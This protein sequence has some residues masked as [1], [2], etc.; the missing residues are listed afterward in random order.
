MVPRRL[1]DSERQELVGRYK[2]GESTAALAEEFGCSPNTV[3]RTVKSLLPPEA[4]AALKASRQK[5]GAVSASASVHVDMVPPRSEVLTTAIAAN[6]DDSVV[7]IDAASA[8]KTAPIISSEELSSEDPSGLALNDA[9]DFGKEPEEQN[10]EYEDPTFF[11]VPTELVP[12]IGINELNNRTKTET[13][14]LSPGVLPNSVY[15]LVD[16]A[17]ELDVRP[18]RDFPELN[19]LDVTDQDRQGLCLFS[20][21]RAAKRQC[22]RSQRVIK[23]PDT[24]VFE[25]TSSYLLKRG[26]TRL[27]IEGALV[28]LDD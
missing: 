18:L 6:S 22:S 27:V 28:S 20:N 23:V 14:P 11:E 7:L 13:R 21:P 2:A 5:S 19:Q 26:I 25:R 4:Y 8:N 9:D 12:L 24:G 10:S 1:S 16:K 15:M 17:V 3:S